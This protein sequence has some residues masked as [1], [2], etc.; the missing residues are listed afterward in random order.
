M[1]LG[2]RMSVDPMGI[3]TADHDPPRFRHGEYEAQVVAP[4]LKTHDT[5]NLQPVGY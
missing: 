2:N 3:K 4:S 5:S 1:L